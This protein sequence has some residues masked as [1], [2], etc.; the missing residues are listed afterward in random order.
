MGL[1]FKCGSELAR[2]GGLMDATNFKT[3]INRD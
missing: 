3:V 1:H 2:D